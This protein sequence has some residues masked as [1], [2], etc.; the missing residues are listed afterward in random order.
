MLGKYFKY[1]KFMLNKEKTE[2][3]KTQWIKFIEKKRL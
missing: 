1:I 3:R 2:D